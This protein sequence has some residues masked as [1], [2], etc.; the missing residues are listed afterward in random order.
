MLAERPAAAGVHHDER[1][2]R[3][4]RRVGLIERNRLAENGERERTKLAARC[5]RAESERDAAEPPQ[6]TTERREEVTRPPP[7]RAPAAHR[8]ATTA[9]T[10]A[11]RAAAAAALRA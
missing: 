3:E 10:S 4:P 2:G 6:R 8:P 9:T 5:A 7:A 1:F 11:R